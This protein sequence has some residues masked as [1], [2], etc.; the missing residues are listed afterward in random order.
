MQVKYNYIYIRYH[1]P[2]G[3]HV[4]TSQVPS[5]WQVIELVLAV[6]PLLQETIPVFPYV[7]SPEATLTVPLSTVGVLQSETW[8]NISIYYTTFVSHL[9]QWKW[10]LGW[11]NKIRVYKHSDNNYIEVITKIKLQTKS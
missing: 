2:I 6:Y 5:A 4:A 11:V 8:R 7:V 1:I 10:T 9:R 3:S